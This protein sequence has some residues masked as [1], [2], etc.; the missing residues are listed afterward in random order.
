MKRKNAKPDRLWVDQGTEFGREFKKFCMSKEQNLLYKKQNKSAVAER[1]IRSLKKVNYCYMEEKGD[2]YVQ[3]MASF[4]N[5]MNTRVNRS[6]GK[7]PINV[8]KPDF[9]STVCKNPII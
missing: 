1:A 9:L 8:K 5:T 3:R 4:A 6:I 7:S 2:E